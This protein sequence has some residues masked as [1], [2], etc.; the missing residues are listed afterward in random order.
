MVYGLDE[1]DRRILYALMTDARGT[2]APDIAEELG[3]SATTV[4]NRIA[5]LEEAGVITGYHAKV[6]FE[7]ADG[8]I[9]NLYVC[10]A[11]VAER[12]TFA[13]KAAAVPGVVH[14][15]ELMTG[16]SNLHV[17][18][19]GENTLDL[20]RITRAIA[21]LGIEIED[22]DLVQTETHL[23]YAPYA[24]GTDEHH[25]RLSDFLSLTGDAEIVEVTVHEAAQITRTT[26][27][28][29]GR[30]G[31][32]APGSLVIAIQRDDEVVTP[33]G[34]TRIEAGDRV[35]IFSRGGVTDEMLDAF[36]ASGH[37]RDG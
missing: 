6:D 18:A 4:R 36:R 22:E 10:N 11:P 23:P 27:E 8:R 35:T 34:D 20:R 3:V 12:E 15:R 19:V 29:A 16:R 13:A 26:L 1:A 30:R 7:R 37:G 17:L 2:T 25:E 24:F 5:K 21:H 31:L 28:S 9:A 14:V 32:L 33:S